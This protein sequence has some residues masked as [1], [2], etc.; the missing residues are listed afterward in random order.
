MHPPSSEDR[1]LVGKLSEDQ[2]EQMSAASVL[3]VES[4]SKTRA[5]EQVFSLPSLVFIESSGLE[6]LA[7]ACTEIVQEISPGCPGH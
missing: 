6:W 4:R 5:L 7:L 3:R 1:D 2:P